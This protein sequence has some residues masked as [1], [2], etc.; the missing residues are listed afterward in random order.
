[1]AYL[2]GR[3]ARSKVEPMSL[4]FRRRRQRRKATQLARMLA[5][6]DTL[7]C[8]RRSRPRRTATLSFR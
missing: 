2:E 8:E 3:S 7:A 5:Q 6:L 4:V 1:M